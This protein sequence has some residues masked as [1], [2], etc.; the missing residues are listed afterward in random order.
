MVRLG[1]EGGSSVCG[2]AEDAE[3]HRKSRN[4][5][6]TVLNNVLHTKKK[7]TIFFYFRILGFWR[8]NAL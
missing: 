7:K 4:Q 5:S 1:P 6:N 8:S 3:M 2:E